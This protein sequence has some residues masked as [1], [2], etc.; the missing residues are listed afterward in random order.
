[1]SFCFLWFPGLIF[2]GST[3]YFIFF[4]YSWFRCWW[5]W[6]WCWLAGE[7]RNSIS[8]TFISW[9]TENQRSTCCDDFPDITGTGKIFQA[10]EA[11]YL[12]LKVSKRLNDLH[13]SP[14]YSCAFFCLH[15]F[16]TVFFIYVK[17][18]IYVVSNVGCFWCYRLIPML[19]CGEEW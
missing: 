14:I 12:F 6:C 18:T 8:A 3:F 9:C 2:S 1:M 10:M 7:T 5:G 19:M 11:N 4:V 17:E 15:L 16:C 13:V